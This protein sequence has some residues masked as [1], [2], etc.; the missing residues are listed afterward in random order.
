MGE[1]TPPEM[2]LE[3]SDHFGDDIQ[4]VELSTELHMLKNI[5]CIVY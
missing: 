2:L 5:C 1:S 3:V 4:R